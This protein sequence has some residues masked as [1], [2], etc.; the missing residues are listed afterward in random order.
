MPVERDEHARKTHAYPKAHAAKVFHPT[1]GRR[2]G[3]PVDV[4]S[5]AGLLEVAVHRRHTPTG[6]RSVGS[7][8]HMMLGGLSIA[9]AICLG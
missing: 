7:V 3:Q 1:S 6:P 2:A 8:A 5:I 9:P 4:D